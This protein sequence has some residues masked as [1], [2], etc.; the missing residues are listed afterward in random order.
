M[1]G[2]WSQASIGTSLR[3]LK[4][5]HFFL[6]YWKFPTTANESIIKEP[7]LLFIPVRSGDSHASPGLSP[8]IQGFT[9]TLSLRNQK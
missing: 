2:N 5:T 1:L 9:L 8:C 4:P 7:T 6:Y 3:K